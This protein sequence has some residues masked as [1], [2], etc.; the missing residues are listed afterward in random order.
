MEKFRIFKNCLLLSVIVLFATTDIKAQINA[1][2]EGQTEMRLNSTTNVPHIRLIELGTEPEGSTRFQMEHELNSTDNWALRAHLASSNQRIG[3][4]YN[5]SA[6]VLYSED[7]QELLVQGRGLFNGNSSTTQPSLN[8][9]EIEDN[10]FSRLFFTNTSTSDRWSL[11]GNLGSTD[12]HRFGFYYNGDPKVIYNESDDGLGVGT[13]SPT[14]KLHLQF[15]GTNGFRVEGDGTGDARGLFLSNDGGAHYVFDDVS[16]DNSL[17][18]QSAN[19]LAFWTNGVNE[20]MRIN[21]TAGEVG[22][23]GGTNVNRRLGIFT[24]NDLYGTYSVNDA[25]GTAYGMYAIAQSNGAQTKYGLN[26]VIGGSTGT[27]NSYGVRGFASTTPDNFWALYGAGDIWYTGTLKAPSD[28]RLKKNI[29]DLE[30]V[31]DRV[32]QLE[33]KT[34]EFDRETY[35]YANLAKGPQVG[36]IAQN[37]QSLF[38]TLVEEERHVYETGVN[39]ETGEVTEEELNILGMSSIEMIPILTKALQEQQVL[40]EEL[41]A[42]IETLKDEK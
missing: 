27:G 23:N 9:R 33:T 36:F 10:D 21:K 22:I 30:P 5:G 16:D 39:Q 2:I 31:L 42:D 7:N 3:W 37:V 28:E 26:G 18:I 4:Y 11:A 17:V 20:R 24:D 29:Q 35:S 19:E 6:R 38:P 13:S 25:S 12:D 32:M 41:R 14:Q 1:D 34:Y 15:S 8:L 40:I